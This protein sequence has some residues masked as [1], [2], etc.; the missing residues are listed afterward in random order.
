MTTP[1][2]RAAA[3]VAARLRPGGP[4]G[5]LRRL[6]AGTTHAVFAVDDP[7]AVLIVVRPGVPEHDVAGALARAAALAALAPVVQPHAVLPQ[8]QHAAGRLVTVWERVP[9]RPGPLDWRQV[10]VA[11]RALHDVDPAGLPGAPLPRADRF[12]GDRASVERLRSS[13]RLTRREAQALSTALDRLHPALSTSPTLPVLLH[14][15]LH[16]PNLLP[17]PGGVVLC[18]LDGL[19]VGPADLD[20]G[21]LLDPGRPGGPAAD[22][23]ARFADGYRAPVPDPHRLRTAA[24]LAH[25]RGTLARLDRPARPV[26]ELWYDRLR[27]AS[28]REAVEDWDRDLHPVT[29]QSRPAQLRRVLRRR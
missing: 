29:A 1:A 22:D 20:L 25:L 27:L 24:R 23:L 16:A 5:P 13:G 19:S 17:G 8:V 7:A 21:V 6:G 26:R 2:A 18:D 9:V 12:D 14:G 3:E 28:W 4:A 11:V 10:G 15:D